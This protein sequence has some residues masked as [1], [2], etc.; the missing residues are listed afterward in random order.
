MIKSM[1][2]FGRG[3]ETFEDMEITV[4]MRSV[5]HRYLEVYQR[6]PRS[7]G[8]LEDSLKAVINEEIKRGK[9][10]LNL[11]IKS[12]G[13]EDIEILPNVNLA[14]KYFEAISEIAK[15]LGVKREVRLETILKYPDVLEIS[16]IEA[17]EESLSQKV[18][19]VANDALSELVEMRIN[20]GKVLKEDIEERLSMLE[21]MALRLDKNSNERINFYRERLFEKMSEVLEDASIDEGRILL[22]AAIYADRSSV[23][24]ETTR[25]KSH[26]SQM[27]EMLRSDEPVGRKLDFLIQEMNR[28]V[29]TIGSKCS[30]LEDTS[31]VVEM[32]AEIEKIR[33]QVQNIE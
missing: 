24:E 28:E 9:I 1:T 13:K 26:F 8:F 14:R 18:L 16:E 22:E 2:G 27:R 32:K 12:K 25:L 10:D 15:E 20:E 4:E 31:T 33:E 7:C 21:E 3:F 5:N 19:K 17:D 6:V 23:E 30:G 29:N 11:K